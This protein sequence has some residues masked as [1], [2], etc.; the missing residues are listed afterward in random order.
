MGSARLCGCLFVTSQSKG[1][2]SGSYMVSVLYRTHLVLAEPITGACGYKIVLLLN[3]AHVRLPR[4]EQ[5]R[6]E[7]F[8]L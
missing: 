6:G 1:K 5:G 8:S 7:H 3:L 2:P 4:A